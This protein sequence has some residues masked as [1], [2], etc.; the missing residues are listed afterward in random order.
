[1]DKN[2]TPCPQCGAFGWV[3]PCSECGYEPIPNESTV[4]AAAI[5]AA[6][7]GSEAPPMPD[8]QRRDLDDEIELDML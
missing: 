2:L 8:M 4:R 6:D 7:K 1:M 5:V 3:F